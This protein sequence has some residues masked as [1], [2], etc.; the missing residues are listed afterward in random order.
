[1]VS[2]SMVAL[3]AALAG[4]NDPGAVRV[5]HTDTTPALALHCVRPGQ[6]ASVK[7]AVLFIHGA[8]FPTRL[9]EGFEFAPRD[10]WLH[11]AATANRVACGL[12][13]S[14]FGAS[15]RPEAL[16]H[17]PENAPPAVTSSDAV[18][19]IAAAVARLRKEY[20]EVA[21]IHL[22]AHS[23]GTIPAAQ[24]AAEHPDALD[25]LTLFGPVVP[26]NG[27]AH[28]EASYAWYPLSATGRY[29]QLK[30][31]GVLPAG[32]DL[33]EPAV[34]ARWADAFA[35]SA[36]PVE[37]QPAGILRIPAGPVFDI[38]ALQ[39][40][41][42]P[43][44]PVAVRVPVFVVYG[45]YDTVVDDAGGKRFLD[46]FS[47]SPLKWR[48]RLDHGTHVMHLETNRHSLYRAVDAFIDTVEND[49]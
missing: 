30:Y 2:L 3:A 17:A 14:G 13:F 24:F 18:V 20:H 42:F 49:R 35:A 41:A 32:L 1:M 27:K 12:D 19:Q 40:G 5:L 8:T 16:R 44:D 11:H 22:V 37:D 7:N 34:H 39:A 46:R 48:L 26:K 33:L 38:N 29:E 9:A 45:N 36:Q 43:Y 31:A 23:W 28:I 25:S 4:E 6:A 47:A 21:S 10:S 15:D